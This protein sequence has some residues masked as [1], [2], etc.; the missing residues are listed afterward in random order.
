[1][2]VCVCVFAVCPSARASAREIYWRTC[3]T[4]IIRRT[5]RLQSL[6]TVSFTDTPA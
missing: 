3:H 5:S 2:C 6:Y 1:M 4:P